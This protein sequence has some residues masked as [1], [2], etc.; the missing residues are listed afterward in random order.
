MTVEILRVNL[1]KST[2]RVEEL[3]EETVTL[4][5]GG[6]SLG[7]L[8]VYREV[9][10]ATDPLSPSNKIV[11]AAGFFNALV[12]GASKVSVVSRSPLTGLI[13]DSSAGDFF[14]PLLRKAGFNGIVVEGASKDPV[15]LWVN[16][17]EAEIRGAEKL[18]SL[19][20]PQATRRIRDETSAKASV[21]VIGPGGENL[22]RFAHIAFDEERA[23]GRGG[24]GAVMGSKK[25]KGIAVYGS[26]KPSVADEESL[27]R[28][29]RKWYDYFASSG[30]YADMRTYGTTNALLYS[31]QMGMSP[32]YNF[33]KPWIPVELAEKL[34]G[35][36][37]KKREAEP[38]WYIHGAS[39]P[40]KCARYAKSRFK[41]FEFL[42]KPEYENLAMLGAS[43]G[44][45]DLD[46]VLY[47]N[48]L[49]DDLGIDSISTGN[50]IAWFLELVE[51][52]LLDPASYGITAE[53][54][55]DAEAVERLINDIAYRRGIGAVLAEGVAEASRIL[56]V[57][58]ERAVHVKKLEAPAWDPRGR[59]GLAV[60]Y[61]TADVGASHL[62]GWP[63][64]RDPPS[65]G[66]ARDVVKSMADARDLDALFDTLGI[67]RFV[68]YPREAIVEFYKYVTGEE[69]SIEDLLLVPR[70]A[71]A[72]ARIHAVLSGLY[73]PLHDDI[74]RRWMEP[75]PEG[76]L[77]GE[78]AFIDEQ[79]KVEA[80]RE[81]YRIRGWHPE[82]GVPL[83]ET[84]ERLGLEW[85][86]GDA[87]K[88]LESA[89]KRSLA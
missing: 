20:V 83:P 21:A 27:S 36:E 4:F 79:D 24:L 53:G 73:P 34:G 64:T 22:V 77:R 67:C 26:K 5:L 38:P 8:L 47:F 9:P 2:V 81:Y 63:R 33:R 48:R 60:S 31:A 57:G 55:G 11:F 80:I 44:V 39:C 43:T 85:A 37:V 65:S 16:D 18:W 35:G 76:P 29:G 59:R 15:Y 70:R 7:T 51:E 10:P 61:A 28:L 13:H 30:R 17:G 19:R 14:G 72:L 62:R 89:M 45:F 32:S 75:E 42:V 6:K 66:P 40:I 69:R 88:A 82:L 49:V 86:R 56:G 71:E 50:V 54:F 58:G 12:P 68:P 78:K 3:D 25:L 52:G 23:A 41:G 1:S 87:L 74:P 84:V 46:A